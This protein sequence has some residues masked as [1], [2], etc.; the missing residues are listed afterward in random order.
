MKKLV[1]RL[2][3]LLLFVAVLAPVVRADV[4]ISELCDP[5]LNYLT[6][7]YIEIYNS[8]A[9]PVTL[10][11]WQLIAVGNGADIFTW[12]LSGSI[13][14]GQA[15]V[16]G[17]TAPVIPFTI[18]FA[19]AG[20]STSN[21]T[22]NGNVNDGAK[23]KN[24][25]GVV[26][27]S[28][29]VPGTDFENK[30]MVRNANIAVPSLTYI[31]SQWTSTPVDYPTQATPGV[32]N[33][34]ISQGPAIG[35]IA[36]A[37]A[38]PLAG[39]TVDVQATVTT[40]TGS[41]TAVTL[42]WGTVSG[43]LPNAIA[44]DNGGAGSTYTTTA[45]IP[46]QAAGATVYFTVTA[47]NDIPDQ[48]VSP[49]QSYGLPTLVTV[50]DIQGLGTVS[51]LAGQTVVTAGVVT[52]GFGTT[53]VI[54]DGAG[55]RSGLWVEG[56]AAPAVGTA[57]ELRGVVQESDANTTLTGA[58]INS[59]AAG[60]LPAAAVVTTGTAAGE[61]WEG[62][63]VQVVDAACTASDPSTP[64]WAV[65]NSGGA[66]AVD[67]LGLV[68]TLV[69]GTRYTITGPV[70]GRVA[71]PGLVPRSA[72]DVVFVGDTA[73]PTVLAVVT[74]TPTSV[75]V[76]FS[77]AVSAAT[78]GLAAN[79]AVTGSTVTAAAP[80]AGLPEA[81]TLTVSTLASGNHTLTVDGVADLYSNVMT[82]VTAPFVF[83]GGNIPVGYYAPAEGLLGESL[84]GVLHAI[85]DAH[86]SI[87]YDRPVDG[88]LH[89]RRQAER[90]GVGHV[91]GHSRRHAALRVHLRRGPGRL[92]RQRG[93]RLQPRALVAVQLVRRDLAD[94]HRPVHHLP[95]GQRREQPAE[96][97]PVRRGR[98]ADLDVAQRKPARALRLP[99]LCG[100]RVR[101][102]RRLQGRLRARLLLHDHAVFR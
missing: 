7:R 10:T 16:A 74:S 61:D 35:A 37:P 23:L 20:W 72:A 17:G 38:S 13:A 3:L 46:G 97:L 4:I 56:A 42:N 9:S 92:G 52:A 75:R 68:P 45:P 63:L 30:T 82:G 51:P 2:T 34:V 70:S 29:A 93:H 32:H 55:A 21:T 8:G 91:F 73:V 28:L 47:A 31:A 24:G 59:T 49:Q 25:S 60:V 58:Q 39:Q 65:T 86:H 95:H 14:P 53:F 102:H 79:Y 94:V 5:R 41:I 77:E 99:R 36:T 66:I 44:M 26:V 43:T 67:D 48:T 22:W 6:D 54:Q 62:V 18:N 84:R 83:Y 80:V 11:G 89:D 87:S 40:T 15:L 33:P 57:V 1:A 85:I 78:A 96:Q 12:N 71:S 19:S 81:V 88:V 76:T 98:R 100:H 50:Q 90:Q 101:A 69:L 64:V 27:E